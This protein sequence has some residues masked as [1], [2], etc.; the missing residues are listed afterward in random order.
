M[1]A[2]KILFIIIAAA[3]IATAAD[4]S[5]KKNFSRE[6]FPLSMTTQYI[7]DSSFGD[8]T[9]KA[10]GSNGFI[11]MNSLADN[12]KYNQKLIMNDKGIFVNETYQR[13]KLLLFIKKENKVTYNRP[14]LRYSFPLFVGK[15]WNDSA[16][17][18]IDDDSNKVNLTGKVVLQED[19]KTPAG[20]FNALKLVTTV[21]SETGSKNVVTEWLAEDVGLVK[22]KIEIKGGG[23]MGFARDILGYG[24]IDFVLREIKK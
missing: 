6:L 2:G 14:L 1:K 23:I 18:Y 11:E 21:E 10:F 8:A 7:Y 16:T 20:I 17:E 5:I 24:T 13:I 3:T 4:K 12:F 22:A 9:I 15:E 19:V